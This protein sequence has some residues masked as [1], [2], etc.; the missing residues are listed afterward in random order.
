MPYPKQEL[1]DRIKRTIDESKITLDYVSPKEEI[2]NNPFRLT[3]NRIIIASMSYASLISQG[4]TLDEAMSPENKGLVEKAGADIIKDM[5]TMSQDDFGLKYF[6]KMATHLEYLTNY[7]KDK[8]V[9]GMPVMDVLSD[10]NQ[11]L[12]YASTMMTDLAQEMDRMKD[13]MFEKYPP[14]EGVENAIKTTPEK[15]DQLKDDGVGLSDHF[16]SYKNVLDASCIILTGQ[17]MAGEKKDPENY[18]IAKMSNLATIEKNR[19]EYKQNG[20]YKQNSLEHSDE[21]SRASE[22][23]DML[24]DSKLKAENFNNFLAE[25]PNNGA[26]FV[27]YMLSAKAQQELFQ[28]DEELK[29]TDIT[30]W[31]GMLNGVKEYQ[32]SKDQLLS[33]IATLAVDTIGDDVKNLSTTDKVVEM[34][35]EGNIIS[36][37]GTSYIGLDSDQMLEKIDNL[38]A[39]VV[40][41]KEVFVYSNN[42]EEK[43]PYKLQATEDG[44]KLADKP[45]EVIDPK[46]KDQV[47]A[48]LM[49]MDKLI[50]STGSTLLDSDEFKNFKKTVTE[51]VAEAK[52][53]RDADKLNAMYEKIQEAAD[54]YCYAKLDQKHNDRR[55]KRFEIADQIRTMGKDL[56]PK[57]RMLRNIAEKMTKTAMKAMLKSKDPKIVKLGQ[58]LSTDR[59][60][61]ETYARNTEKSENFQRSFQKETLASLKAT[62]SK[63]SVEVAIKATTEPTNTKVLDTNKE[64]GGMALQ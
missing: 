56:S 13:F 22:E 5:N 58:K 12:F 32:K 23:A 41:G 15:L 28:F 33:T 35:R 36:G 7:V 52:K 45:S 14:K 4:M 6:D 48:N 47:L 54:N 42:G 20:I 10:E 44:I 57:D 31:A 49:K 2:T 60:A 37:D 55:S 11:N 40:N 34:L 29:V 16:N 3:T 50:K 9:P 26:N 51:S 1:I 62:F 17:N 27:N 38:Y 59:K 8:F 39:D 18:G 21:L 63:G 25:D 64:K 30:N 19:L 46:M 43:L 61:F 24:Y 53:T